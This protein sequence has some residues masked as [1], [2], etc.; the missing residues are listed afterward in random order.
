MDAIRPPKPAV[1]AGGKMIPLRD[2]AHIIRAATVAPVP[3]PNVG[4]G[5]KGFTGL[6]GIGEFIKFSPMQL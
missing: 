2:S 3:A 1:R 4:A 6:T 5:I